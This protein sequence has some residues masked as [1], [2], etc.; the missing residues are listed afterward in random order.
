LVS[1]HATTFDARRDLQQLYALLDTTVGKNAALDNEVGIERRNA[2][3]SSG[4]G[5][6]AR[7]DTPA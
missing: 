1:P 2:R 4:F 3:K 7:P 5:R 6:S